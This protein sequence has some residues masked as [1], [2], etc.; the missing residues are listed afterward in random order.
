MSGQDEVVATL[1]DALR[2]AEWALAA[3]INHDRVGWVHQQVLAKI[4]NVL[5]A[6]AAEGPA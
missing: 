6:H 2:R 3:A 4:R 5:S 1:V